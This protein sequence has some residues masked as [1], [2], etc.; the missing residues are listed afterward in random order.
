MG[1]L[2][3]MIDYEGIILLKRKVLSLQKLILS[4]MILLSIIPSIPLKKNNL[5]II[6]KNL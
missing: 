1:P 4:I 2:Y 3:I 5:S 6:A